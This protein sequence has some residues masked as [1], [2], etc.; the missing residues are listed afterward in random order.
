MTI[1]QTS[2]VALIVT[3]AF[4]VMCALFVAG[5]IHCLLTAWGSK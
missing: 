2:A 4:W 3:V 1:L 5:I